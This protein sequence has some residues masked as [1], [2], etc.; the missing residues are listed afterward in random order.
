[1][2]AELTIPF[3]QIWSIAAIAAVLFGVPVALFSQRVPWLICV[4]IAGT[5]IL[6]VTL[7]I[8]DSWK[9]SQVEGIARGILPMAAMPYNFFG[10]GR[11]KRHV[12]FR[13]PDRDNPEEQA[14]FG[15]LDTSV[16]GPHKP[17]KIIKDDFGNSLYVVDC[18]KFLTVLWQR[19]AE[20]SDK[21]TEMSLIHAMH[22]Y[23]EM[24][25]ISSQLEQLLRD[26]TVLDVI[27]SD[28][29]GNAALTLNRTGE[30]VMREMLKKMKESEIRPIKPAEL[31]RAGG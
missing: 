17:T 2:K 23:G 31:E 25:G 9:I 18:E 26:K 11:Y 12:V 27:K 1:M 21:V 10:I 5:T 4:P 22:R 19:M 14:M 20:N 24:R 28:F 8:L 16:R 7:D 13:L 15:F 6:I 3:K 29:R 30:S